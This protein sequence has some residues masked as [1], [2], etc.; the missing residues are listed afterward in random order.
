MQDLPE[1]VQ[2]SK[3]K[4]SL[5]EVR[6][7]SM[8]LLQWQQLVCTG[9]RRLESQNVRLVLQRVD[10][11]QGTSAQHKQDVGVF[12]LLWQQSNASIES[13]TAVMKLKECDIY[14]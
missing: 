10:G 1:Q 6:T 3:E 13:L 12:I 11:I 4:A 5:Q 8:R 14:N 2:H 7:F 9:L